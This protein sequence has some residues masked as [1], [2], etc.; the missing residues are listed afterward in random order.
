VSEKGCRYYLPPFALS[1]S[2]MEVLRMFYQGDVAY[3]DSRLGLLIGFL[4]DHRLLDDTVVV[5]VSDHGENFGDHGLIEH[6][7][8]LYNSVLHVPLLIRYP[9]RVGPGQVRDAPVSTIH[10]MDTILDLTGAGRAESSLLDAPPEPAIHAEVENLVGMLK[11][12]LASEPSAAGFDFTP[13]DKSL[14]C[15]YEGDWKLI[16]SSDGRLELYDTADDWAETKDLSAA[17][18]D[19]VRSMAGRLTA[20]RQ[21]LA[22]PK[23]DRPPRSPDRAVREALKS[24]GYVR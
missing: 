16:R 3:M 8:S 13:F 22:K 17:E 23:L 5:V 12:Q 15:V 21:G 2:D 9:A 19:R 20:W 14:E 7:F 6:S 1:A 10:L 4:R 18:P 11:V 24:L